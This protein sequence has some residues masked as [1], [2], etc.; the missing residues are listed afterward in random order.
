MFVLLF[1]VYKISQTTKLNIIEMWLTDKSTCGTDIDR[2]DTV[3]KDT[4]KPINQ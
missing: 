2:I 3:I 4:Q 1:I